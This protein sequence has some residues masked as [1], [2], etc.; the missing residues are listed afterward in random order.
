V[1]FRYASFSSQNKYKKKESCLIGKTQLKKGGDPNPDVIGVNRT[2][3]K[4]N[5]RRLHYKLS[6]IEGFARHTAPIKKRN[7]DLSVRISTK[8]GGG[9]SLRLRRSVKKKNPSFFKLGFQ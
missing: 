9:T 3:P 4:K 6:L 5:S 2:I 1:G 8:K 7:P